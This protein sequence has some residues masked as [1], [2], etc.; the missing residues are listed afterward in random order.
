VTLQ[1]LKPAL[2]TAAKIAE[3]TDLPLRKVERLLHLAAS[4]EVVQKGIS[5][6]IE[7][8]GRPGP[9]GRR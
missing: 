3:T 4:P 8:A 9:G 1:K 6:G 7:V 2:S 5:D